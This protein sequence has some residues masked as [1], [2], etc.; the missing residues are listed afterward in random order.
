MKNRHLVPVVRVAWFWPVT[1][2]YTILRQKPRLTEL[3]GVVDVVFE[4]GTMKTK[5]PSNIWTHSRHKNSQATLETGLRCAIHQP[6]I[7]HIDHRLDQRLVMLAK[8]RRNKEYHRKRKKTL[9]TS[10]IASASADIWGEPLP[11]PKWS[12]HDSIRSQTRQLVLSLFHELCILTTLHFTFKVRMGTWLAVSRPLNWICI[13]LA[14]SIGKAH[15]QQKLGLWKWTLKHGTSH[16]RHDCTT[17]KTSKSLR[18]DVR[19]HCPACGFNESGPWRGGLSWNLDIKSFWGR[20]DVDSEQVLQVL[21]VLEHLKHSWHCSDFNLAFQ[22]E[23]PFRTPWWAKQVR[24]TWA[25]LISSSSTC[26]GPIS[27]NTSTLSLRGTLESIKTFAR[28]FGHVW[29]SSLATRKGQ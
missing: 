9:P 25:A 20:H 14:H 10:C 15:L 11:P 21:Q 29:G 7:H 8:P 3:V 4:I 28:A 27:A 16:V 1:C 23:E 6:Y 18:F 13:K 5:A 12:R 2:R 19:Q 26:E 22:R 24:C 17:Q